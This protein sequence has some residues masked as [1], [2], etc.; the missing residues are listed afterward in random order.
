MLPKENRLTRKKDF[1]T[2]FK[3]GQSAKY[4]FLIVKVIKNHLPEKRF[5]FVVSKKVSNKAV[6]RNSVR[7]RLQN[8]VFN[9][10]RDVQ[11]S[12]DVVIITLP[13]IEKLGFSEIEKSV[14]QVFKKLKLI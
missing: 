10:L 5:G 14:G 3:G 1:D 13:G 2:V 8:T 6:V 12:V 9:I 11:S 4:D 7:R